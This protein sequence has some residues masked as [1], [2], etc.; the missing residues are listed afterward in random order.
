MEQVKLLSMTV[1][2]AVLVWTAADSLVNEAVSI[3]VTFEVVP[4]AATPPSMIEIIEPEGGSFELEISGPRRIVED[5]QSQAPLRA[6]LRIPDRPTGS[7]VVPLSKEYLKSELAD[8]FNEFGRLTVVAVDPPEL[9]ISV[10]HLVS[11]DVEIRLERLT[12]PYEVPPQLE[13]AST[14]VRMRESRY[15]EMAPQGGPLQLD[16]SADVDRQFREHPAGQRLAIP[17][18]LDPSSFG[19]DA[20]FDP[21]TVEVAGKV[22]AQRSTAE[23]TAVPVLLAVSFANLEKSYRPIARDGS[24]M[25]IVAPT[26]TVTGPTEDVARLRRGDTRAYGI[27]RLREVDLEEL[28]ATK[29]MIPEYHLPPRLELAEPPQPVEFKLTETPAPQAGD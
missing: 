20:E 17:L 14:T 15:R 28:G 13:R 12:L 11:R 2:L 29:L 21:G 3:G 9:G 4:S 22:K 16:I 27:I 10:D 18:S 26:I 5:V 7:D 1:V 24:P 25:D 23:V 8:Q 19:T 6:R